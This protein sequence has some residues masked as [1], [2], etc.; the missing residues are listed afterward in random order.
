MTATNEIAPT[1]A[2]GIPVYYYTRDE[3]I[4]E[5]RQE[6]AVY[7]QTYELPS[8]K[9]ADLVDREVIIPSIEVIKWYHIYDELQFL[10]EMTP[11]TGTL[12]TTTKSFTNPVSTGILS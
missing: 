8:E 6:L 3:R 11:T 7:E 5:C 12:G 4:A 9:M 1:T 10:L 2:S